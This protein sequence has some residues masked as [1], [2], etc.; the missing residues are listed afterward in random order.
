M[1]G[2]VRSYNFSR[3]S[4]DGFMHDAA[5]QE[6]RSEFGGRMADPCFF[7]PLRALAGCLTSLHVIRWL[8]YEHD[9]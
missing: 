7:P 6:T 5:L 2:V 4:V 9:C 1:Q 8:T 3:S